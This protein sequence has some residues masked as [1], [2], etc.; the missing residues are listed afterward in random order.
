MATAAVAWANE[1]GSARRGD[2]GTAAPGAAAA[3]GAVA[4]EVVGRSAQGRPIEVVRRGDRAALTTVL[5]VGSIHGTEPAGH[6]VIAQLRR[7]A[8]PDGLRLLLVPTANPDGAAAG[9][10]QNARGVDL[11]RNFPFRWRGH[12]RP[13]DTY[14]PGRA[15][16]SEPETRAMQALVRREGPDVTVWYHQA[17]R[18][19]TLVP[20]A[21]PALIR[22]YGARTGLPSRV[23]PP[24]RGTATSWQNHTFPGTSAF[25]VELPAGPLTAAAARRH[26]RAVLAVGELAAGAAPAMAWAP[27]PPIVQRPI[28]FGP[29]RRRQMAAYSLRHYG[30]ATARLT[31]PKVI[32]E[33]YTAT[34]SY[35]PAWNTFAANAPDV[36][37]RERPGV[38][39]HFLID[40]DGTITQLVPLTLRCRHTIGLNHVA[41]GVEHVGVSDAGV[42]T[43]RR[44]LA[45]S[46]RLTRWL[47]GRF[48]IRTRDVIGHAESLSSP[49]YHED[50]AALRGRTHGDFAHAT[51]RAYRAMLSHAF[52]S[53]G[54]RVAGTPA[55]T[56]SS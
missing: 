50:V 5:V 41:V 16:A 13:F 11:N 53:R 2:Q 20:R 42:M 32:V 43:N 28:P 27:R 44:Q 25:V 54:T 55:R 51:M 56:A 1:G 24:Y 35:A 22:A 9:T 21:D 40:G 34:S 30:D 12:G 46:L 18:L 8:V 26:A 47:Q 10:R 19:V 3:H 48:G 45:A 36:E 7:M 15:P 39:A 37:L 38:C 14:F 52:S 6:A 4:R 49:Y 33:H 23:L 31:D 29:E 17:L